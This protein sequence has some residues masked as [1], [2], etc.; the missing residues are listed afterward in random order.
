MKLKTYCQKTDQCKF[1][2]NFT[3]DVAYRRFNQNLLGFRCQ[4]KC[5]CVMLVCYHLVLRVK[6][7]RNCRGIVQPTF[8]CLMHMRLALRTV[9]HTLN[10]CS[11]A[12]VIQGPY[13]APPLCSRDLFH[14]AD[15]RPSTHYTFLMSHLTGSTA[16]FQG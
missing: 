13:A 1:H 12:M 5:I 3:A 9:S 11:H 7:R 10:F 16:Y 15:W 4:L 8:I 6:S 14:P 2:N